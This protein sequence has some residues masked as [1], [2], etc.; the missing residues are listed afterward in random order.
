MEDN[1][2]NIL[3][4]CKEKYCPEQIFAYET[5]DISTTVQF[6]RCVLYVD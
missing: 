2:N 5:T 4:A 3:T 6:S 1:K